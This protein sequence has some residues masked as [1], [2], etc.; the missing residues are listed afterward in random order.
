MSHQVP[1][2]LHARGRK[3]KALLA[4]GVVLGLGA[5]MTLAAWTDDVWVS[6]SF[7]AGTF[8]VQGAVDSAGTVWREYGSS[9]SSEVGGLNFTFTPTAMSPGQSVYAPLNLRVG[10]DSSPYNAAIT[11][12]S[13]PTAP[14]SGA[15]LAFF[16]KLRIS[17]YG[18]SPAN[19]N[20]EGTD[21]KNPT[22]TPTLPGYDY[23][24]LNTTSTSTLL[25]LVGSTSAPQGVCFR[26]TLDSSATSAVQGGQANG[27]T[28]RF[29]AVS[30]PA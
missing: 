9:E 27:L 26:I 15:D 29:N 14:A 10:P 30:V 16:D 4:G 11:V 12:A 28:W 19:C 18:V 23:E 8:N 25:T 21:G 24:S 17:L 20:F 22:P 1:V 2:D 5:T 13:A 6:G 3:R 7:N